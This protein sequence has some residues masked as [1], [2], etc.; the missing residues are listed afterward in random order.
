M[1]EPT[2]HAARLREIAGRT[3]FVP[4]SAG[5]QIR[6]A[7]D[8]L[9]RLSDEVFRLRAQRDAAS[10]GAGERSTPARRV[11][12][13]PCRCGEQGDGMRSAVGEAGPEAGLEAVEC[14]ACGRRGPWAETREEAIV[15][16]NKDRST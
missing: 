5:Q 3:V 14:M 10:G 9:D 2:D 12:P 7:A 6:E 11:L 1:T 13:V 16:W 8:E 4:T 15:A